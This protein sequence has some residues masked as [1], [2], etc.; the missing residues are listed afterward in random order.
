MKHIDCDSHIV[1]SGAFDE[2]APEYWEKRPR[3][4]KDESGSSRM[5]YEARER[6]VPEY[7]RHIRHIFSPR[8]RDPR[9]NDPLAR[10]ADM[11]KA[12]FDVQVL[13]P[14]N[15]LFYNDVEPKLAASV[16]YSH[17]NAISRIV[18]SHRGKFIGLTTVPLEDPQLAIQELR[19]AVREL[20]L[21]GPV[22]PPT[23]K[24]GVDLDAEELWPFYAEVEKLD[25]PIMVHP[26]NTGPMP[27]GWS[28]TRHYATR[29]YAFWSALGHPTANSLSLANLLFGGVLDAFPRLRFCFLEGG[30]THVPHLMDGLSVIAEGEGDYSGLKQKPKRSP[31]EYLDRLY[32]SIRA[33]ETLLGP[34]I[35]RLGVGSW[36][37]GSDY[38]HADVTGSRATVRVILG[39]ED[40]SPE[41]KAAILGK[42]ALRL[43]G[44]G[45]GA[46]ASH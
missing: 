4:V 26:V 17:N 35:E 29:G 20:G 23:I 18:K 31:Y 37:I 32:F 1:P 21:S 8:R 30:G 12:Q 33:D 27:G 44:I 38:P 15:G 9:S 43:F 28:L 22:V 14:S 34:V 46:A 11:D 24:G 3:V 13:V 39:R 10:I 16:C 6:N 19:R 40:L 45:D 36:V 2:V 7:A 41:A 25:V 42:N 5:V